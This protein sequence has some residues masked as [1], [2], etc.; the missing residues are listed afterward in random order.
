MATLNIHILHIEDDAL[1]QKMVSRVLKRTFGATVITAASGQEAAALIEE[2]PGKWA[3]VLSDWNIS[4]K[5]NGGDVFSL[6][7]GKHPVLIT[8]YVFMSD[9]TNAVKLASEVGVP[10]LEKPASVDDICKALLPM[11][12][13][14]SH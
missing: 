5:M 12:K 3:A 13:R 7:V 11:I 9:D 1:I 10:C 2:D 8:K 4:G 14:A 6:A